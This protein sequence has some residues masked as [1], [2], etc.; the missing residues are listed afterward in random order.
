MPVA[1]G[2]LNKEDFEKEFF[3]NGNWFSEELSL[4]Q[5][6]DHPKPEIMFNENYPFTG[7]SKHM[8]EHFSNYS[9]WVKKFFQKNKL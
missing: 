5:L 2:F 6:K 1:N 4:L 3:W 9:N 7:S 8:D